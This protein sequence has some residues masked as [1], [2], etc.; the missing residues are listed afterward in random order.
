M[1]LTQLTYLVAVDTHRHFGKAAAHCFVSQ[2]TLSAQLQKLE[3]ELGV[4]VFDRSRKPVV[5]TEI[6]VQILEQARL[7]LRESKRFEDL[8]AVASR[9]MAGTLHLG[10]IPTLA[11]Y[12]LPM[13]V[14]VFA[15]QYPAVTLTIHE[16]LTEQV[17]EGLQDDTLDMGLVAS[18]KPVPGIQDHPLFTEPFVAYVSVDHRLAGQ[19]LI[20]GPDLSLEDLWLLKEGHCFRDQALQVCGEES[21]TYGVHQSILFESGNLETL[22]KLVDHMGGMTLLPYL[23]TLYLSEERLERHVRLFSD[24]IPGRQVN[25]VVRRAYLKKHLIDAW[26]TVLLDNLPEELKVATGVVR[27]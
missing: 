19:R 21:D 7:V 23:A 12:L 27:P 11:S 15:A 16:L 18:H 5:P 26:K 8:I 14:P 22:Q 1:T 10:I 2:P 25:L 17:L 9:E 20:S 24:P 3:E 6:G 13:I 4:S